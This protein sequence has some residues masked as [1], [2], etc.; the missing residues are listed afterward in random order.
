MSASVG[1]EDIAT[2]ARLAAAA[3]SSS[4]RKDRSPGISFDG[5]YADYVV[6]P[7]NAVAQMPDELKDAEAAPLL[8]AGITTYNSLRNSGARPGDIVAILGIG[9]LGHLGVQ[10]AAKS[11]YRTVAIARGD[12]KAPLAKQLGAHVYIDNQ[13]QDFAAELQKLGGAVVI[14]ST[15][16]DARDACSGRERPRPQWQAHHQRRA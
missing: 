8:C 10:F 7:A 14:L 3:I 6:A 15:V 4:A 9:G 16:T 11:G 13:Q 12:D 1:M 5:G 2:T